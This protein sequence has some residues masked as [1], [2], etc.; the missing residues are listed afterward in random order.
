MLDSAPWSLLRSRPHVYVMSN[1]VL[2]ELLGLR[3]DLQSI[4][5][6]DNT[7]YTTIFCR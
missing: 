2:L 1:Y 5:V 4:K 3:T 6:S 7:I